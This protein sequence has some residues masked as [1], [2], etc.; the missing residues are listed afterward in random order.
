MKPVIVSQKQIELDRFYAIAL[1]KIGKGQTAI[2]EDFTLVAAAK[3]DSSENKISFNLLESKANG[4]DI[5]DLG[6]NLLAVGDIAYINKITVYL[7]KV[8][9]SAKEFAVI[10]LTY[11]E[12]SIYVGV[13]E[14]VKEVDALQALY[15]GSLNFE[16]NRTTLLKGFSMRKFLYSPLRQLSDDV[17]PN[18][19]DDAAVEMSI[20]PIITGADDIE[21]NILLPKV[22]KIVRELLEGNIDAEGKDKTGYEN[23]VYIHFEGFRA[24]KCAPEFIAYREKNNK[25]LGISE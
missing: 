25:S 13:K 9:K 18:I 23:M 8:N 22:S 24:A 15:E 6:L 7:K 10:P 12:K 14:G 17:Y 3:L 4:S 16:R 11:P 20:K 21:F 5:K 1:D 2:V 19:N